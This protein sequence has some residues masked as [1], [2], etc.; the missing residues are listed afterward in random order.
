V[1]FD[2]V[3]GGH[4]GDAKGSN[5]SAKLTAPGGLGGQASGR[6]QLFINAPTR[7]ASGERGSTRLFQ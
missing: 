5:G 2:S 1:G 4:G 6:V 3:S 7:S